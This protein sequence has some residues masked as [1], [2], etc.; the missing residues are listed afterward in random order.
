[1]ANHT[2]EQIAPHMALL[3]LA[4]I[5]RGYSPLDALRLLCGR[6]MVDSMVASLY[7]EL[8]GKEARS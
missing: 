1:M 6:E 2:V 3:A 4:L 5:Q 8:R 7:D